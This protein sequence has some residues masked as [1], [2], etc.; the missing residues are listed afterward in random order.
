MA[1]QRICERVRLGTPVEMVMDSVDFLLSVR[2][3]KE[4]GHKRDQSHD[5]PEFM[6]V[7]PF[8]AQE[9]LDRATSFCVGPMSDVLKS[10]LDEVWEDVKDRDPWYIDAVEREEFIPHL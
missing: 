3:K 4:K 9:I 1:E 6:E 5:L 8:L 2:C 7:E 10:F